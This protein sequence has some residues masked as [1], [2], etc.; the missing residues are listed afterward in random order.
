MLIDILIRW[1]RW[2]TNPLSSGHLRQ[3]T[4]TL[5][6]FLHSEEIVVLT[7]LRR[8]GKSTVLYQIMDS[9]IDQSI[10]QKA[11]LHINFE[12]PALA[13]YLNLKILDELYDLYRSQIYPRGKAYLF[14]DEIQNIPEW[15][16][17]VRARNE[18]EDIKIF[19]TGSSGRLMSRELATLLTGRH[20]SFEMFPLNM[21][22]LLQ[23]FAIDL[24]PKPWPFAPPPLIQNSLNF[25]LKWG[26]LPKIVLAEQDIQREKLLSQ[27][28]D[29][30]LL[31]DIAM[32][33]DIRDITSLRAIAVHVLTQ[34]GSLISFQRIAAIFNISPVMAQNYCYYLQEA[35]LTEL[36]PFYSLKA[37]LRQ[38]NPQKLHA[39]DLG[40]R[41]QVGLSG[42][43]DQGR[44]IESLVYN[45]LKQVKNDGIFYLKKEGEIDFLLRRNNNIVALIQ[46][47]SDGLDNEKVFKRETK[48]F[49]DLSDFPHAKLIIITN[50]RSIPKDIHLNTSAKII[51]LWQFLLEPEIVLH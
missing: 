3:I 29:D 1:N 24:P 20:V 49:Q 39:T 44:L 10:D 34:T 27:Y 11:M 50:S 22:E 13:P 37:A 38:R 35:Y 21:K 32:R 47:V 41:N 26:S 31:K 7:G 6:P 45:A 23:F 42:S 43:I 4:S 28:F 36:L 46:V 12:E 2:G 33:H 15:E 25:K 8:S 14:L 30:I 40:I 19:I 48:A 18:T 9:L 16:R 17:W 5:S 51:P